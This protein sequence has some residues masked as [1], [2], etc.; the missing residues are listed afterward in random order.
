MLSNTNNQNSFLYSP[1]DAEQKTTPPASPKRGSKLSLSTEAGGS[2]IEK[3]KV[4]YLTQLSEFD[5]RK[6]IIEF[7]SSWMDAASNDFIEDKAAYQRL[8]KF[9]QNMI[10]IAKQMSNSDEAKQVSIG[11]LNGLSDFCSSLSSSR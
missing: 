3:K 8:E 10:P 6:A 1:N 9:I 4:N 11:L 2:A 5:R 7:L